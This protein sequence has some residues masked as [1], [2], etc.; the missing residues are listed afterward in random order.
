MYLNT[1]KYDVLRLEKK[2]I[3][4]STMERL[5]VDVERKITKFVQLKLLDKSIGQTFNGIITGV[6][7]W[8]IYVE[9]DNGC[10]EGLVSVKSLKDDNY[11]YDES[12]RSFIGRR[13]GKKYT[14]GQKLLV[15]IKSINLL[16]K[17]MDLIIV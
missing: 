5:Y 2:C 3:H 7:K 16:K 17:E 10:A 4:F 9:I 12:F 8:G 13:R 1:E 14:L 15:E 11:Y 6:V